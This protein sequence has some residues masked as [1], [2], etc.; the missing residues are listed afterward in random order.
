VNDASTSVEKLRLLPEDKRH[1]RRGTRVS[2][3]KVT[4]PLEIKVASDVSCLNWNCIAC[5]GCWFLYQLRQISRIVR[6]AVNTSVLNLEQTRAQYIYI[7][8]P[9]FKGNR[10]L[11]VH[12]MYAS[13][14]IAIDTYKHWSVLWFQISLCSGKMRIYMDLR[15]RTQEASVI[16]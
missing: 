15:R 13:L 5:R 14:M 6:S 8:D 3:S 2:D 11:S 10:L 7:D 1:L 12:T 4:L 9:R 16:F